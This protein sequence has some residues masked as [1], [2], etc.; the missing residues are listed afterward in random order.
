MIDSRPN[1]D[2]SY[3]LVNPFTKQVIERV[4]EP[5]SIKPLDRIVY[6]YE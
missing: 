4:Y 1:G 5:I 6:L 3:S 2:T